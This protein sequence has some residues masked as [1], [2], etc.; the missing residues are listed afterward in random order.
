MI[1]LQS[2]LWSFTQKPFFMN[3]ILYLIIRMS[4]RKTKSE[5]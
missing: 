1:N 4:R 2:S 3:M 5:R